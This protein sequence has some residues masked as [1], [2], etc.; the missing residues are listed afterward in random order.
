M[1]LTI[2][3]NNLIAILIARNFWRLGPLRLNVKAIIPTEYTT[4][5]IAGEF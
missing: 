3:H 5:L 2:Y 4:F 1:I